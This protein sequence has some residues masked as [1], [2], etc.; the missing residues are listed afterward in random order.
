LKGKIN[1]RIDVYRKRIANYVP[2]RNRI[3]Y[4]EFEDSSEASDPIFEDEDEE[5]YMQTYGKEDASSDVREHLSRL[6]S[7]SSDDTTSARKQDP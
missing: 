3:I 1:N 5:D 6:Y 7:R 4:E 2:R